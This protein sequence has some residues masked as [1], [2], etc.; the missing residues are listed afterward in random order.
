[1]LVVLFFRTSKISSDHYWITWNTWPESLESITG[2]IRTEFRSAGVTSSGIPSAMATKLITSAPMS[3]SA[4]MSKSITILQFCDMTRCFIINHTVFE[5]LAQWSRN[6][7]N[8]C[9]SIRFKNK[10]WSQ[11]VRE[12]SIKILFMYLYMFMDGNVRMECS[13]LQVTLLL[14]RKILFYWLLSYLERFGNQ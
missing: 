13:H 9:A 14:H 7:P 2:F 1:M 11:F 12:K 5:G 4:S 6:A 8:R 10:Q 3:Y